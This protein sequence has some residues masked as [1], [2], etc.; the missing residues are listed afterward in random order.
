M[1]YAAID[2]W[3]KV[4][5]TILSGGLWLY[6]YLLNRNRVTNVR[7]STLEGAMEKSLVSHSTRLTVV[8]QAQV[9]APSH[10]D[11]ARLHLRID[12][13]AGGV[14]RIE[15]ENAAQTRILNLVY[16]SLVK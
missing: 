9:H 16:E 5:L 2:F 13:V 1:N 14:K 3:W 15:G 10:H 12:D 4:T 11:L 7:I 8:E 6:L